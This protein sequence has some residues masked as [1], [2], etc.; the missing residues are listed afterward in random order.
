MGTYD[1]AIGEVL[2]TGIHKRS[3]ATIKRAEQV[4]YAIAAG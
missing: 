3:P 2:P 4:A 1:L